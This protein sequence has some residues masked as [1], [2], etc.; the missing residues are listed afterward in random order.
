MTMLLGVVSWIVLGLIVGF[1]ATKIVNLRGDDP[2]LGVG[3]GAIG[4]V[5]GGWLYSL[6]SGNAVAISNLKTLLFAAIA[7]V[8]ALVSWHSWRRW[9]SAF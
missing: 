2:R 5:I 1:I 4:A 8:V 3:M 7:A 6:I 9:N